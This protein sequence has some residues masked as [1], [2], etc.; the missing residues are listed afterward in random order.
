[1]CL[2]QKEAA[3]SMGPV[4]G[5]VGS[6]AGAPLSQ[7]TGSETERTQRDMAAQHRQ[8]DANERSERASGIG[9]T[10]HDQESS[11]R[12]ADGRR[13]WEAPTK[14]GKDGKDQPSDGTAVGEA[15]QSKDPS[16]QSGTKLDLTG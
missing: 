6:A 4:G 2:L 15:R 1:M 10:E 11:E 16:G 13:L 12:D 9:Q 7:T 3:M 5:L 14:P 8:L